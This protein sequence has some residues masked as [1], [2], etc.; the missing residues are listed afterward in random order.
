MNKLMQHVVEKFA[1]DFDNAAVTSLVE[2]R[3]LEERERCAAI[4]DNLAE[5]PLSSGQ[6]TAMAIAQIIRRQIPNAH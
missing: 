4:A 2:Q 6:T 5:V 3:V 1:K